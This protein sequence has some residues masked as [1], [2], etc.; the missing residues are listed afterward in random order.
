MRKVKQFLKEA[1]LEEYWAA[2]ESNYR[3]ITQLNLIYPKP[4]VVC[5]YAQCRCLD[6]SI[7]ANFG[8]RLCTTATI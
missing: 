8:C 6:F 3:S 1:H 5:S 4:T 7:V 2:F